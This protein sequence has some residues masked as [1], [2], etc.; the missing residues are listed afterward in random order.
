M[1]AKTTHVS[2]DRS[3]SEIEK[4]LQHYGADQFAYGWEDRSALIAFR[5]NG[6]SVRFTL[7]M[8]SP[9]DD[10]FVF[11]ETGRERKPTATTKVWEQAT[12]TLL[13]G[14]AKWMLTG[15]VRGVVSGLG[16]LDLVIALQV[17][18]DLWKSMRVDRND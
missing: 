8:P 17:G 13:P 18:V 6:R 10:I 1:Y 4:V 12:R 14:A 9:Q 7:P 11:T 2:A 3:R 16:A 5:A 15:W